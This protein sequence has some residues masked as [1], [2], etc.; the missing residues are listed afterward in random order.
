MKESLL[1][2]YL[3]YVDMGVNTNNSPKV[4][5]NMKEWIMS[6]SNE[7]SNELLLSIEKYKS[8]IKG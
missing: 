6:L 2:T 7:E 1:T 8:N 5:A 4:R 3:Q